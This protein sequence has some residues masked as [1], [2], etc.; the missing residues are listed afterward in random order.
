MARKIQVKRGPKV[1]LP[2]LSVGEFGFTT[3]TKEVFIGSDSEN[4]KLA[5]DEQL[6]TKL[7]SYDE[8]LAE[9]DSKVTSFDS[10]LAQKAS[11]TEVRLNSDKLELEDMSESTL[12][13]MS[14][15]ATFNLLSV[16]QDN[17]V[18]LFKLSDN[19]LKWKGYEAFVN[20]SS[21]SLYFCTMFDAT[22]LTVTA[23]VRMK[24]EFEIYME[25]VFSTLS[26]RNYMNNNAVLTDIS[27]YASSATSIPYA[28]G[29]KKIVIEDSGNFIYTTSNYDYVKPY[30]V[31]AIPEGT[32]TYKKFFIRNLRLF[33][34]GAELPLLQVGKYTNAS[35]QSY[36]KNSDL[37]PVLLA[38]E[39]SIPKKLSQLENDIQI[40]VSSK[41][42]SGKK[43]NFLG[44]SITYGAWKNGASWTTV[45]PYHQY[46]KDLLGLSVAR[47]YGVSSTCISP[48]ADYTGGENANAFVNRYSSMDSDADLVVV[49]GGTNDFGHNV[50]LGVMGDTTNTTFYGALD[51]LMRGLTIKYAGKKIVFMTP[52]HRNQTSDNNETNTIGVKLSQYVSAIKEMAQRYSIAVIDTYSM[53]GISPFIPEIV[54]AYMEDKLHPNAAGHQLLANNIVG[55]FESI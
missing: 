19:A 39:K 12:G 51:I 7:T 23:N 40:P 49:F 38:T 29:Y 33:V 35:S 4:V 8:Q 45:T 21:A 17:T 48:N 5:S 22:N 42:W 28:G 44:D 34:D 31:F 30:L 37:A 18:D 6:T 16:P 1:N 20:S 10:Q 11:K 36:V 13:A 43:A 55:Q 2:T 9:V 53:S 24:L 27:T 25:D 52:M 47:N 26:V 32:G 3:D 54:T 14:G 50:P 41:R 15:N 46:L